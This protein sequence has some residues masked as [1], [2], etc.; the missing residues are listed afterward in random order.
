MTFGG[1]RGRTRGSDGRL[2]D[3]KQQADRGYQAH[4][5]RHQTAARRT[6]WW[7]MG[8]FGRLIALIVAFVRLVTIRPLAA[9]GN[10]SK[11]CGSRLRG[12]AGELKRRKRRK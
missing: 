9:L 2:Y 4:E 10:W 7:V 5:R 3:S 6:K 12:T 8:W 1:D 11:D